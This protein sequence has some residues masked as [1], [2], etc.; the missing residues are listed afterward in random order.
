MAS[1]KTGTR[2]PR[3]SDATGAG[4]GARRH[5]PVA[6]GE[7]EEHMVPGGVMLA[8]NSSRPELLTPQMAGMPWSPELQA[9]ILEVLR[10]LLERRGELET[11]V[12]ELHERV[13]DQEGAIE[14]ARDLISSA[15]DALCEVQ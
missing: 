9:G 5:A 15:E 2:A 14:R 10:M 4:K 1:K 11:E 6:F 3:K 13:A 12:E 8:L 7:N